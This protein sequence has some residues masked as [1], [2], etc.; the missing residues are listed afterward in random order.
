MAQYIFETI[1][2]ADAAN[3]TSEDQLFFQSA[4]VSQL[5]VVDTLGVGGGGD[6]ITLSFAGHSATFSAAALS[7]ASNMTSSGLAFS[8]GD[9][10]S[11]GTAAAD[12]LAPNDAG[13]GHNQMIYGFDGDDTIDLT[14][15][16][17]RANATVMGGDGK[18]II[19]GFSSGTDLNGHITETDLLMGG[20]GNDVIYGGAGN[21]HLYGN[22]NTTVAG[23]PDGNDVLQG[24]AGNDYIQGNAGEDM[25]Y[26]GFGNDR[27]YGGAD[28]DL[29]LGEV[30]NDY[31]QGN[32][33]QDLLHGGGGDD[34]LHGGADG[35]VL[36]GEE[37]NDILI[38]DAG[39]DS[40]SGDA[41]YDTLTGGQGADQFR[42]GSDSPDDHVAYPGG[43]ESGRID[44]VTDFAV[45]EDSL[46]FFFPVDYIYHQAD[47][48]I[49]TSGAA[50]ETY[51]EQLMES[52]THSGEVAAIQVG[53]DTYLFW[54]SAFHDITGA[55][56]HVINQAAELLGVRASGINLATLS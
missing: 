50:A 54:S 30:G 10:L 18:D 41:G 5:G 27:L 37:G 47:G 28:S 43:P 51:A 52:E 2:A 6:A 22:T 13:S 44:M 55:P 48:I 21:D 8:N 1:S 23:E 45:G 4:M 32:K 46:S 9:A 33:G 16:A 39:A 53:N 15:H 17:T 12:N 3:F 36:Y 49:F 14:I 34:T 38:G 42:F 24:G 11:L 26:G 40:L 56:G 7:S 35:D 31:I 25:I 19:H 29:I 20:G